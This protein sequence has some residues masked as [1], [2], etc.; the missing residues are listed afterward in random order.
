MSRYENLGSGGSG[1]GDSGMASH[2]RGREVLLCGG[3]GLADRQWNCRRFIAYTHRR[4]GCSVTDQK[5]SI[6]GQ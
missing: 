3:R 4:Y 6:D 1:L 2:G 5:V